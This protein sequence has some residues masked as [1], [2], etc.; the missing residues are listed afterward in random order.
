MISKLPHVGT[1]IFT[2]M[3]ALAQKYNAVNLSQGFPNFKVEKELLDSVS[4]A[5]NG[6]KNQYAPMQG[7]LGLREQIVNKYN[8]RYGVEYSSIDE[9]TITAGATQAIFTIIASLVNEGDEVIMFDPSYDCYAPTVDLFKGTPIHLSLNFPE[10]KINWDEFEASISNK[11]KLVIINT[12]HNPTGS[13]ISSQDMQRLNDLS[14]KH[15]FYVLSDE[16]YEHIIFDEE[17]HQSV[18]LYPELKKR[19]YIVGSFGKTFHVTG[20]KIGYCIAPRELTTEFRKVHQ[21]NVFCVSYPMQD[22]IA[23]FIS[24]ENNYN[25]LEK[26][27]QEKRD[28]FSSLIKGSKFKILPSKGTYFML[29]DYSNISSEND[30]D[31]AK[32]ITEEYA[33]A[34][35]PVSVF[36]KTKEDNKVIRVCFAKTNETLEQAAKIINSIQ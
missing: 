11:T 20:W 31:F 30:V 10:Y 6:Q 15:N 16:V 26:F 32:R 21:F 2:E 3:S 9:I 22:A 8:I 17:K 25:T 23:N 36:Y 14:A 5:L 24:N 7:H 28:Y 27:Y 18:C 35:I 33:L 13:V 1:T 29:L 34:T 19:S 12:P 4:R